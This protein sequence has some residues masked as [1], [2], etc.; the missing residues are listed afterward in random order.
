MSG[1]GPQG[2]HTSDIT[3]VPTSLE[4][5]KASDVHACPRSWYPGQQDGASSHC[6]FLQHSSGPRGEAMECGVWAPGST[7]K[8]SRG[9]VPGATCGPRTSALLPG[10][11]AEREAMLM[12]Q[13]ATWGLNFYASDTLSAGQ[14][15]VLEAT[16]CQSLPL[17]T[18]STLLSP[19]P[20]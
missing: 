7:Q 6:P 18:S 5:V 10:L 16:L 13:G 11:K 8:P 15:F 14:G 1:S 20:V 2:G 4:S 9:K 19:H 17:V 12:V 3:A